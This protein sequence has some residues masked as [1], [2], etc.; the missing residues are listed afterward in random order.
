[1]KKHSIKFLNIV[2]D[3]KC[4]IRETNVEEVKAKMD[5]GEK[6]FF[7]LFVLRYFIALLLTTVWFIIT[8]M[9]QMVIEYSSFLKN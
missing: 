6:F 4:R 2:N 1:M 7:V 9:L 5:R 8:Y 3:S